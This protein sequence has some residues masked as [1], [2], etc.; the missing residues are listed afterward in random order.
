LE[1]GLANMKRGVRMNNEKVT[2]TKAVADAIETLRA[3]WKLDENIIDSYV[4]Y[5]SYHHHWESHM[6]TLRKGV[7]LDTLIRALYI[8]YDVEKTAGEVAHEKIRRAYDKRDHFAQSRALSNRNYTFR[9][10]YRDG[11]RD[12][13]DTLG[14][15]IEGVNA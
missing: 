12:T 9:R 1:R 10:G 3:N 7:T 4:N 14:I 2:V 8:G 15:Q 11:V 5:G 6:I 13:L